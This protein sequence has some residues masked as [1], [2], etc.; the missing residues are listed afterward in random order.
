[1]QSAQLW[2]DV[3]GSCGIAGRLDIAA[4]VFLPP[5][6][7]LPPSATVV[8]ALPGGG[9]S[10]GYYDMHFDGHTD[11]SQAAHHTERGYAVVAIDHLGVG[12]STPEVCNELT[13]EQIAAANHAAVERISERLETGTAV[14]GYPAIVVGRR[15]GIGQSM[16]GGVTIVMAAR[17]NTYD[18]IAVLGFSGIHTVLPFPDMAEATLVAERV[19]QSATSVGLSA[20]A[21][22]Q[23]S[24]LI[25]DF[26]Y[27]FFWSDIP[28]DI[29]RADTE[30][31]Y[32]IRADAPVFGSA[33]VPACAVTLLTEGVV[34]EE[35][36]A[37][38]C[39][40]FV[41]LGERDTAPRSHAEPGAYISS[42]DVTLYICPQMAHMHNFASTR[43]LLWDRLV[44]WYSA[45]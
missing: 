42:S 35:A 36:A 43:K 25:P 34:A 26:F 32:P 44:G 40:V 7:R 21:V 19:E 6:E 37:V 10:R 15:I 20:S 4:T 14:P 2:V 18:A 27:P 23:A 29:L 28:P 31:G 39:P 30:G 33:T 8:F 5:P 17:H 16:G 45:L 3:S 13:V 38:R 41:G 9:Y 11:Y 1:M 24:A 22:A 12:E